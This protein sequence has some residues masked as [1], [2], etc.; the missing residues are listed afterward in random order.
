MILK[1]YGVS[2]GLHN[3]TKGILCTIYTCVVDLSKYGLHSDRYII[4][5]LANP[6]WP[7]N[8]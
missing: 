4:C 6:I 8:Y 2:T 5:V 1:E 7:A 3:W